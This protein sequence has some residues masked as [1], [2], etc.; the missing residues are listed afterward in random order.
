MTVSWLHGR[1][2]HT[3]RVEVL[4]EHFA[5]L[6]ARD[7]SVLD[8]G[9]GDGLLSAAIGQRRPDITIRGIDVLVRDKTAIAVDPFD[10]EQIPFDSAAFDTVI[11]VDVLHHTN[12]PQK[13]LAEAAR[14]ASKQIVLKDHY[15]RGFAAGRT[16]AFMDRV[17]NKRHGVE[18]PCNYLMQSQWEQLYQSCGLRVAQCRESLGLYPPPLRWFFERGLHFV[19][20]L[21]DVAPESSG[22][23]DP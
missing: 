10:G 12:S 2:I 7:A 20:S 11:L 4:A 18:I 8:V 23:S 16:L 9:C 22:S 14:V 6:I 15:L 21:E 1:F 17:G 3:R 19:A 5:D 13:L